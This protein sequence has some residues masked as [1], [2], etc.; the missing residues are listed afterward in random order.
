M[1]HARTFVRFEALCSVNVCVC[2]RVC[3]VCMYACMYLLA[4]VFMFSSSSI[5]CTYFQA[6]ASWCVT[7]VVYVNRDCI[8]VCLVWCY[9]FT[10]S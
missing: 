2:A 9:V 4:R 6:Y 5:Q 3:G 8:L 7:P 1:Y 10:V